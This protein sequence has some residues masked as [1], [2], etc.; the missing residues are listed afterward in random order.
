LFNPLTE[1]NLGELVLVFKETIMIAISLNQRSAIG[2]KDV[3]KA[4]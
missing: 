1:E 4:E 2:I 3:H